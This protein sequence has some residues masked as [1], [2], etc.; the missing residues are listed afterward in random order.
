MIYNYRLLEKENE[1]TEK[2]KEKEEVPVVSI[3]YVHV[4][5][6]LHV[7]VQVGECK[8]TFEAINLRIMAEKI[9][10][11]HVYV[12]ETFYETD[13]T[14]YGYILIIWLRYHIVCN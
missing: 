7:T 14:D 8:L 10:S 3:C 12:S 6:L 2:E 9:W 11:V 13:L 1:A 4:S 5:Y